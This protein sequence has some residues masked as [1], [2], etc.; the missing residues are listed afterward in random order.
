MSLNVVMNTENTIK[1]SKPRSTTYFTNFAIELKRNFLDW[2]TRRLAVTAEKIEYDG[3]SILCSNIQAVRYGSVQTY[4]N[5]IKTGK[6][7]EI[8][9]KSFDG[10]VF[11]ITF[12]SAKVFKVNRKLEDIYLSIL[13]A[14]WT[15]LLSGMVPRAIEDVKNGMNFKAGNCEISNKG[16]KLKVR[17]FLRSKEVF[18]EWKDCMKSYKNGCL[19]LSSRH[20]SKE[21]CRVNLLK[22]WNGVVLALMLDYLWKERR[23]YDIFG[24]KAA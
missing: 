6:T 16:M 20:K 12:A 5:G 2:K 22:E 14:L 17:R 11:K 21:K 10:T 7:Y 9:F 13:E 18:V 23:V 1:E 8:A 3:K 24:V 19:I 15:N 4:I